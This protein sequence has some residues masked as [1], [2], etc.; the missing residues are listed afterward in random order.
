MNVE[1]PHWMWLQAL[2]V[3]EEAERLQRGFVRYLGPGEQA[4]S[5][6]P[7]VDIY[8]HQAGVVLL[9][10]LPGVA[11]EDIEIRLED[12]ALIVSATRLVSCPPDRSLIRRLEIP[13]GRFV[14]RIALS[15]PTRIAESRYRDGCLEIRLVP[16]AGGE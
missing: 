6:E 2:A 12:A 15:G 14:R 7:P 11:A 16:A 8:E 3:A 4:V 5:W 10:A 1:G 9:I 13:H